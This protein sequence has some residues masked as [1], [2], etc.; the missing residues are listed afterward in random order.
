M[1]KIRCI[2]VEQ[3]QY[4]R[5]RVRLWS[6]KER[7]LGYATYMSLFQ[8]NHDSELLLPISAGLG[9]K[10]FISFFFLMLLLLPRLVFTAQDMGEETLEVV[11][12]I[13]R[14]FPPQY[15]LDK[16]GLP[17]GFAVE[18][19]DAV[20]RE[21]GIKVTYRIQD[22]WKETMAVLERGEAQLI[23]NL[24]I[25]QERRRFANFTVPVETFA[26]S[27]FVRKS[28]VGLKTLD[29]MSGR[30]VGVAEGNVAV[31]LL[32][33][34]ADL[35]T[36]LYNGFSDMLLDLVS[37]RVDAVVYP[38]PVVWK[39]AQ[40]VGLDHRI[41]ALSPPLLEVKRS[42]AIG[43]GQPL[44]Y[45][46]LQ[47]GVAA[48]VRSDAYEQIFS[49]W[50]SK[51]KPFWT[52]MRVLWTMVVALGF[53][54]AGLMAWRYST[55]LRLN[56]SL[57]T[58]TEQRRRTEAKLQQLNE[59]LEEKVQE[60]TAE[61]NDKNEVLIVEVTERRETE[62]S[63]LRFRKLLDQALDAIAVIDPASGRYIE[64]NQPM[65][66][67]LCVDREA[68]LVRHIYDFSKS[69]ASRVQ[70]L[71]MVEQMRQKDQITAEDQGFRA[72]G[73]PYVVEIKAHNAEEDGR[74]YVIAVF[75]DISER[76]Q[77]EELLQLRQKLSD[78]VYK[79]DQE[80]LLQ[81]AL[82]TAERLTGSQIGFFH[83]VEPNQ[84]TIA[85][86]TW[87]TRTLKE[88]CFAAGEG[89]H[90]PVS[91]AGVWVDCIHQRRPVIHND[92]A[93]LEHKKGLP[94]GHAELL[95]ELTVPVMREN[96]IVAVIGV[97]N[98]PQ[99]YTQKD[100][101]TV[102]QL[103][104]MAFDYVERN[105]TEQ[106]IEY[107]AYYD[108]LTGLPNRSLLMD[109]MRQA[110]AQ[111]RRSKKLL[112][113]CY[114]DLDGF[115]PINDQFGHHVGDALL[116]NLAERLTQG[117][118]EGDTMA[119]LGGDEFVV[120]LADLSTS[121]EC[122]EVVQRILETV[123]MPITV[124][125]H[126]LQVSGSIGVTIFPTDDSA[127]DV[128]LRHAD[129]TMYQ[130]K[131]AGKST[132]HM[133]DPVQ[134]QNIRLRHEILDEFESSLRRDQLLLHYQPKVDLT[135]GQVVGAEAL[136]RWQH[137]GRGLLYP[138]EFLPYIENHAQ[139]LELGEWVVRAALEQ[140][141][142]WRKQGLTLPVSVNISPRHIQQ[143][144]F[145]EF[146]SGLFKDSPE[147]VPDELE[148][149]V[150]ETVG[151]GD[152]A[153]VVEVMNACTA[154]GVHFSLD[155]F[156]TGY[157]SLTY[158]HKLPIEILK[159]DQNFVRDM[160]D[161]AGDL[162][163]IEGV[164]RMADTLQRPVVAEGVE[165][166]EVALMLLHLG[167]RYA[168]GYGIARPM[169]AERFPGWLEEWEGETVWH[170]LQQAIKAGPENYDL[171]VAV[172]SHRRW[173]DEVVQYLR[174]TPGTKLPHMGERQCQFGR[175]FR[176]IGQVRYGSRPIY[177]FI[178]P[179]H[180]QIHALANS[181]VIQAKSGQR[182]DVLARLDEL[183]DLSDELV[184]ML[185]KLGKQ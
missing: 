61:L 184:G 77:I 31:R 64:F 100:V 47:K 120:L 152:T 132:Y 168:Q 171:S 183:T 68:L 5:N 8:E 99:E 131:A 84:E 19:M 125:E 76:K 14:H 89:M 27:L 49:K 153:K 56:R 1:L 105:Q 166:V 164:L 38:E 130:A 143:P 96:K 137:P 51:P 172:F 71:E 175:W 28:D 7:R 70:W 161:E 115:K 9:T 80:Q 69:I 150:V 22:T 87:S 182:E 109:R 114:L 97:G 141:L 30:L 10:G 126:P 119:R 95:R 149:E 13:P 83:F 167:C 181:L 16:Q 44:L 147:M 140:Q 177:S 154:L 36:R 45:Q 91:E 12:A 108:V 40:E 82:D 163:I 103:S 25:T 158:F 74:E 66:D 160:L 20:A 90:Y 41:H 133:F 50:Y 81:T 37:G 136:L 92:Y 98:K 101:M 176:G 48:F 73:T 173:I 26:V 34:R 15:I 111:S 157:S 46:R 142:I 122:E 60:R 159:I 39:L 6:N 54:I 121:Y 65:C 179:K 4:R 129:Q 57:S 146:L 17:G 135:N 3:V 23:P 113:I 178:Q 67:F 93:A 59:G 43:K 21:V 18:V 112:A 32:G 128:L 86:Q 138:N 169:P 24:G 29:D 145:A 85:L 118:R 78:L 123:S 94:E 55:V 162:D 106:Q 52:V 58:E 33:D 88:M 102:V 35:K 139:E 62:R 124:E 63:L 11:A 107:M 174:A 127:P 148:L 104:D 2:H 155:D 151:I 144:R 170:H 72:D 53:V 117:L 42:V 134:E 180:D 165:S 156:G 116:V 75:R 185:K 110:I 79:G